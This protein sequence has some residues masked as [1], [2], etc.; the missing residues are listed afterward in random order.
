M[1]KSLKKSKKPMIS[2]TMIKSVK[3]MT[4]LDSLLLNKREEIQEAIHSKVASDLISM[5]SFHHSSV[6]GEE[7]LEEPVLKE[8][9]MF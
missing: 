8:E 5:I 2:S 3:L 4:S 9:M 1:K 6:E 7:V